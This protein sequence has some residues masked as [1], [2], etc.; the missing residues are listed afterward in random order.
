MLIVILTMM[1]MKYLLQYVIMSRDLFG[2]NLNGLMETDND[3]AEQDQT[4][5]SG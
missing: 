5:Y 3:I 4:K 2:C 1:M